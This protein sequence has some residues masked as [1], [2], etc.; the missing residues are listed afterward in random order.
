[1]LGPWQAALFIAT[2]AVLALVVPPLSVVSGAALVLVALRRGIEPG[3][4]VLLLASI[5]GAA[6][7]Y[8]SIGSAAPIASFTLVYWVPL[9]GLAIVLRQSISLGRT[10]Q[11]VAALGCALV[12]VAF[13]V[14][15]NPNQ[16]VPPL[17]AEWQQWLVDQGG[18]TAEQSAQFVAPIE[19][20]QPFLPG[21]LVA[22]SMLSL[23]LSLLLGRWWQALLFNPGGFQQEFHSL[24]LGPVLA[25]ITLVLGVAA[26]WFEI[27]LLTNLSAVF[28]IMYLIQ[29]A[30]VVHS[31][32]A[33]LGLSSAWLFGFYL[34]VGTVLQ[35]PVVLFA[36][37]DTWADFRSRIK[38]AGEGS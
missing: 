37:I 15:G 24:R 11:V 22:G 27:S 7:C 35:K 19:L 33:K 17:L 4:K 10:L 9:F 5:G 6:L 26:W 13:W 28:A 31:L 8:L 25:I 38:P 29:G 21:V 16:W 20:V 12:V 30:A 1:M 23:V 34:L 18:L 2:A 14:L 32:V 36:L 3:I